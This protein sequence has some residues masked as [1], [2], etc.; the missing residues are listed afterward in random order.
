MK[1]KL[2]TLLLF[3]S[4]LL[5]A[6]EIDTT[7]YFGKSTYWT[8]EIKNIFGDLPNPPWYDYFVWGQKIK[9]QDDIVINNVYYKKFDYRADIRALRQ[10]NQKVFAIGYSSDTEFLLYDFGLEVGDSIPYPNDAEQRKAYVISTD[11]ITLYNGIKYKTI[12]LQDTWGNTNGWV[13]GIIDIGV[14]EGNFPYPKPIPTCICGYYYN[15]NF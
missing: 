10:E 14:Q 11:S 2:L 4:I 5:A 9:I 8:Y 12:T 13:E 15:L 1:R 3:A 7:S 6:Q